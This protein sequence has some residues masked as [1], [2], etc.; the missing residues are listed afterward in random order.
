MP[1][2]SSMRSPFPGVDPHLEHPALWPDVHNS[3]IGAIRDELSPRLRPRYYVALERRVY[4]FKP[5]D[6]AFIGRP[7]VAVVSP[8]TQPLGGRKA[9][10]HT[11]LLEVEVPMIDEVGETFLEVHEVGTGQVV[12]IVELLSP[13]NKL[14][15]KGRQDYEEKRDQVFQSRTSL[16]EIDL[17]RAGDPMPLVGDSTRT[18]YRILVSRGT[19]RPR[20]H[21][22]AFGVREAIPS[23]SLPLAPGDAEAIVEFNTIV[24]DLY[25]RASFDLRLDYAQPPVPALSD[26]DGAW[27][28]KLVESGFQH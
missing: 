13:A 12:T 17:L 8:S 27:A 4:S 3:I 10:S 23:F 6:L 2:N 9:Q 19:Q 22:H 26:D 1:Y 24:H 18:D 25:E 16:V 28:K 21:L 15:A 14:H 20:A 7:D 11:G 5:D